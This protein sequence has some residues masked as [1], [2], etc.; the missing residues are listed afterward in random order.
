MS[1]TWLTPAAAAVGVHYK[2]VCLRI[3]DDALANH[4]RLEATNA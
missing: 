4:L 2:T 1:S 3:S